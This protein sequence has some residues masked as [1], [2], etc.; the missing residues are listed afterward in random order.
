[1]CDCRRLSR[2]N[3]LKG[4]AGII[5]L[6]ELSG[7]S[8][9]ASAQS[10]VATPALYGEKKKVPVLC[11][12]CAQRCPAYAI[13]QQGQVVAMDKNPVNQYA[14]ICAK[15]RAAPAA[16]YSQHRIKTPLIREGERGEGKFRPASWPEALDLVAHQMQRLRKEHKTERLFYLYR[17]TSAAGYDKGF[18][19]LF[20]T[21]NIVDYADTCWLGTAYAQKSVFGQG[22]AGA[23][24]S[25]WEHADYGLIIGK[26]LGGSVIGYGWSGLFGKG[27]RHGLPLTIVDPRRPPEMGQ[28][29]AQWL[30]IRPGTDYAFVLGV[31]HY[32]IK[33]RWYNDAYLK[34]Y[35]NIDALINID[36]LQPIHLTHPSDDYR[37]YDTLKKSVVGSKQATKP[38]YEG[39]FTVNGEVCKPAWQLL[40]AQLLDNKPSD[41][42]VVCGISEKDM[43]SVASRLYKAMP[44][45][46]VEVG[47]RFARHSSDMK[48][49][50]AINHLNVLLGNLG[51]EGGILANKNASLGSVPVDFPIPDKPPFTEWY[52]QSD[53]DSW[54]V[55]NTSH[56]ALIA[57][58]FK[59]G[60]P[61]QPEML[62]LWG[63]NLLG[64]AAGGEDI[65][66]MLKEVPSVVGVSPFWNDSLMFADV[67]LPDCT[68]L[69][70]DEPFSAD[71]KTRVPVI[72]V[73]QKAME[74]LYDSKSGYWIVTELAKRVFDAPTYHHYFSELENDG[75]M[76]YWKKQLEGVGNIT[77]EE[78]K[79]LPNT[80]SDLQL[81]GGWSSTHPVD[82][83]VPHTPSGK[84][85][86]YSVMLAQKWLMLR[87]AHPDYP[88]MDYAS[89]LHIP[90][91]PRWLEQK[92]KLGDDE[93]IPV[94]GFS[95]LGSFTG[96][97]SRDND[98]LEFLQKAT[99]YTS[100]FM[101]AERAGRL[102]LKTGDTID[103]WYEK[104]PD[105]VQRAKV[106]VNETTHPDVLFCYYCA[107]NGRFG[108]KQFENN[109]VS[110]G[111]NPNQF[112]FTRFAPGIKSH[113][114]QDIILKIKRVIS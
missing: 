17:Y 109:T 104:V 20:G 47:Y 33:N 64:G 114:P 72:G 49:Q 68:F 90:V 29:T 32:L 22:G 42:S 103:I 93:F 67:I 62:F 86:L 82:S 69:E 43:E 94:T 41:M 111:M 101:N 10:L 36:T 30:P 75:L 71:Y 6:S 95:P 51:Q 25:D 61:Y 70:R 85:E 73:H 26:N 88:D 8:A 46:F 96:A 74:P 14:G 2:R 57:E 79:T 50:W 18:F 113:T 100:V 76:P 56:R 40:R 16:L 108:P 107:G 63:N 12:M 4:S 9:E 39:T 97:Q 11:Y 66:A 28:V 37:V 112:G 60:K 84:I 102:Q 44:R 21:P 89:P 1:M 7:L 13:V 55:E 87:Q 81:A 54:G 53:P 105:S 59:T 38:A 65:S 3:F 52:R 83:F 5:A 34:Q 77:A 45:C 31:M 35:T 23:F 110:Q 27:Q 80:V 99:H 24:T 15:G 106:F 91:F 58:A 78:Q 19:H 98:V 92:A 48:A